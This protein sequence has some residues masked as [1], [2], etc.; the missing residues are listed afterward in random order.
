MGIMWGCIVGGKWREAK[1]EQG[2]LLNVFFLQK[3]VF[4]LLNKN[5]KSKTQETCVKRGVLS[6]QMI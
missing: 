4:S 1:F 2:K 5:V 6:F 3:F